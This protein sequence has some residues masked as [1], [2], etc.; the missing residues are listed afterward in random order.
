VR[1]RRNPRRRQR[2]RSGFRSRGVRCA[3]VVLGLGRAGG[4][5]KVLPVAHLRNVGP[6]QLANGAGMEIFF[7]L[8]KK[9]NW[10]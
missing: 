10:L 8:F 5:A 9:K 6:T 7:A 1:H 2:R 3:K 4:A